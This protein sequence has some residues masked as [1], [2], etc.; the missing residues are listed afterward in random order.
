MEAR[1]ATVRSAGRAAIL[2]DMRAL[3]YK[4]VRTGADLVW[5]W[6]AEK[7]AINRRKHGLPLSIAEVALA[8]PLALSQPD[9]HP[10]GDRWN[11][12][13]TVHERTLFIVHTW[14]GDDTPGV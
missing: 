1:C 14:P 7:D 9:R 5:T 8:D 12:L 13:A 10:D 4:Y 3:R 11:T 2:F 6:N